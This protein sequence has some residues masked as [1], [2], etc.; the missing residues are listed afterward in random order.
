[1]RTGVVMWPVEEW[2]AMG[3]RWARAETLGFHTAWVYDHLAWRGHTPWDEAFC[4]LA[5]AAASTS[6][7]RLGT[8]VTTPNFRTP[9][10]TAAAIRTLDRISVGRL[11]VGIGAG[12]DDHT[13]DGDVL[14][15]DFSARERAERFEEW[16]R[17]VDTLLREAPVSLSGDHWQVR[18]A[19][20][21]VGLVQQ[22]RPPLWL[23]GNG[24]RGLRLT[25]E[26]GDGWIASG[27]GDDPVGYVRAR[28]ARLEELCA[29]SGRDFAA[30]PKVLLTGFTDE[31]WLGSVAAYEDLC[32]TYEEIGITDVALHWPRPNTRFDAPW[33]TFEA[34]AERSRTTGE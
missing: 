23:A 5:A 1:M 18:E 16:T 29:E 6:T 30:M 32:D 10:P 11:T 17:Q 20:I 8:L 3:E 25:A 34:I 2:P 4:T 7:I 19:S 12:G 21:G 27:R 15:R 14:D 9:V 13:S 31:P 28:L 26:L 24:P 22:P 33:A